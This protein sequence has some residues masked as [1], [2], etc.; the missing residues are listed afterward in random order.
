MPD[1][2]FD[3]GNDD[4]AFWVFAA[5]SAQEYGFPQPSPP[6]PSWLIIAEN[7]WQDFVTR[8]NTTTCNG[9]LKWQ[10]YPQNAGYDYKSSISNGAFFQISARLARYT[11]NQTY[12]DWANKIWDWSSGVGLID[13]AYT[14]FD[15]TDDTINCSR[16][17]H[18]LWSYNIGSYLYGAAI[19]QNF[20]NGSTIWRE[21]TEGLLNAATS[22]FFSPSSNATDVMFETQCEPENSC[23]TTITAI[24]FCSNWYT[25]SSFC[26]R[27]STVLHRLR[28][29]QL[30]RSLVLRWL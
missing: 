3:E 14:V 21:R 24:C 4:Q 19:M 20:T 12:V 11:G 6:I 25:A 26:C 27:S 13:D 10:F 9:G 17:D 15:G 1:E 8:W 22:I 28:K 2:K 5:L 30:R 7:A 29:Q 23:D 18:D 16:V